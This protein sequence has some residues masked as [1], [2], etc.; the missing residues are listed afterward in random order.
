MDER[1]IV[2]QL[3]GCRRG[4]GPLP[5]AAGGL[6]AEE[7]EQRPKALPSHLRRTPVDILPAQVVA[8]HGVER[9]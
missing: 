2:E 9:E 4:Q 8:H 7:T 6:A 5:V 3:E 1:K